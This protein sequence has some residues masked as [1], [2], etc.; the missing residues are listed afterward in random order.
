MP[1]K[2]G[3][4]TVRTQ[5]TRRTHNAQERALLDTLTGVHPRAACAGEPC[6]VH[7]PTD[8]PLRSW[9]LLWRGDRGIFERVCEHGVGHPDPDQFVYW[10]RTG[11]P[12]QRVH[13]CCGC[14]GD[15]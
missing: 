2:T 3:E 13:G 12:W 5:L 1:E 10:D 6:V 8:H 7:N 11:Q 14:C 9:P 4:P 15:W